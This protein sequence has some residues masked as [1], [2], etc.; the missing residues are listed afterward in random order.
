MR[1]R[2]GD[3]WTAL[4][5]GAMEEDARRSGEIRDAVGIS[6]MVLSSKLK[7]LRRDGIV[8]RGAYA[9]MPPR[10]A[11]SFASLGFTRRTVARSA[12]GRDR[13]GAQ[14]AR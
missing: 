7:A 10:V 2:I 5:V 8:G 3:R 4:F 14:A 6:V 11:D 12:C 9:E 1:D 13:R